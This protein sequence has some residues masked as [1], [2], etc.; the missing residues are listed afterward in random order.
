MGAV[1]KSVFPGPSTCFTGP[2]TISRTKPEMMKPMIVATPQAISEMIRT[3][4]SSSRC[5][6]TVI[7]RSSSGGTTVGLAMTGAG[8]AV[9]LGSLGVGRRLY[10]GGRPVRRRMGLSRRICGSAPLDF[11]RQIGGGPTELAHR[12]PDGAADFGKLS[13]TI[14][15]QHDRQDDDEDVPVTEKTRHSDSL[16]GPI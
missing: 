13:R 4:R 2:S 15:D 10:V 1:K 8:G 14:D 7:R 12:L 3:R 11:I 16:C 9:G 6:M 5:S